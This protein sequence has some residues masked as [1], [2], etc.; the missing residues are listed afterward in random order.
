M[1]AQWRIPTTFVAATSLL[2]TPLGAAPPL[3]SQM[4]ATSKASIAIRVS[5]APRMGVN[6]VEEAQSFGASGRTDGALCVWLSA[7]LRAYT[8]RLQSL[9]KEGPQTSV[10]PV[11]QGILVQVASR[12]GSV[13]LVPGKA[14]EAIAFPSAAACG[15]ISAMSDL[16]AQD[17]QHGSVVA[18][19]LILAPE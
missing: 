11:H 18:A 14:V 1:A 15:R 13:K 9:A 2:Q 7:P 5:V 3:V 8:L 10:T 4:G 12:P 17:V 19:L 6:R 16:L